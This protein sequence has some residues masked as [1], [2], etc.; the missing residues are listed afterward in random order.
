[1][2]TM[3][4]AR[5]LVSFMLVAAIDRFVVPSSMRCSISFCEVTRNDF[6]PSA[7][8]FCVVLTGES[9]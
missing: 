2:E 6:K 5:E 3:V 4:C 1:M 8:W 7:V 9:E